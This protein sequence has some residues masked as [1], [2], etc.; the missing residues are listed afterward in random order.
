MKK[1]L[2]ILFFSVL[3]VVAAFVIYLKSNPPLVINGYT[4]ADGNPTNRLIEIEN[5]GI[6]ELQLQ[7]IL[8]DEKYPES[9]KLI[10]SKSEPFE[11]GTKIENNPNMTFHKLTQVRIFPSQYIDRQAIG[12]QPQHYAIQVNAT[13]IQKVTIQYNYLKIPFT[14]TAELQPNNEQEND[15]KLK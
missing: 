9:A 12:K 6:R 14:L 1:I 5:K 3:V 10:V 11:I 13:T 7:T 15:T 4:S 2:F 8:V